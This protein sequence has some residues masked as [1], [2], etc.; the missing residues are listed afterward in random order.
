MPRYAISDTTHPAG[1]QCL[2]GETAIAARNTCAA[3][4]AIQ[5]GVIHLRML[6]TEPHRELLDRLSD[7]FQAAD[8]RTPK[9]LVG[10]EAVEGE[11][12]AVLDQELRLDQDVLSDPICLERHHLSHAGSSCMRSSRTN[13]LPR[14]ASSGT[15]SWAQVV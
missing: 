9:H 1:T 15:C 14:S 2:Q 11:P 12:L 7:H 6:P 5:A 10:I 8:E 3:C 13:S 4:A